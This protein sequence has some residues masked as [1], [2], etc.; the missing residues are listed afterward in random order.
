MKT[1][2]DKTPEASP[3]A[4]AVG[5]RLD[6]SVGRPA[7]ARDEFLAGICVALQCAAAAG[8]EVLWG[9]IVRTAGVN[10]ILHY[11]ANVEPCEWEMAGFSRLA[12][13]ELRLN[14]PR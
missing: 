8:C 4:P 14:K 10:E 9:E 11:A 6:Q 3:A 7:P 2:R 12:R 1:A 5:I 13:Q